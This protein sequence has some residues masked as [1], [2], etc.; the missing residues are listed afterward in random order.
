MEK[1]NKSQKI[2]E[3][4]AKE[5][6]AVIE[7][8]VE[9]LLSRVGEKKITA[10]ELLKMISFITVKITEAVSEQTKMPLDK[11]NDDYIAILVQGF[12]ANKE[13]LSYEKNNTGIES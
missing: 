4:R 8:V 12:K 9:I 6:Y 7:Q 10:Y 2:E 5:L 13:L 3:V 1:K 11:V